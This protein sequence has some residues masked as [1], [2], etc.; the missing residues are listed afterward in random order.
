MKQF[1]LSKDG[2]NYGPMTIEQMLQY[3]VDANS[4]VWGYT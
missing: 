4:L 1:Y 2:Q 3:G